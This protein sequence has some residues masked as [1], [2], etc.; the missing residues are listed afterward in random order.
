[1]I[2]FPLIAAAVSTTFAVLLLRQYARKRRIPQLAWGVSLAMFAVASL[3]VAL[4][5]TQQWDPTLYR[6]FYLFGA[7]LTVPW[8]ALGSIALLNKRE[9]T[10]PAAVVVVVLSI[11]GFIKVIGAKV[12]MAITTTTSS[13]STTKTIFGH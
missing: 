12:T 8:L 13:G 3:I 6:I 5:T 9:L 7:M 1:M 2:I 4:G 11:Y 10:L